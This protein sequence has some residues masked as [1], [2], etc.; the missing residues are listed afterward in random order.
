MTVASKP[1][2]TDPINPIFN[3]QSNQP[4][5]EGQVNYTHIFSPNVVNNFIGSILWYSAIFQS[6]NQQAALNVFPAVLSVGDTNMTALGPGAT[7]L[8]QVSSSH[9]GAMF[10]QWQLVNDLSI[11]RGNHTFKLGVN[12][13][14]DDVSDFTAGEE[15]F[16]FN[17]REHGELR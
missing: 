3:T 4:E 5:D 2:F 6:A 13:R 11:A 8:R 1:T 7:T 16:P 15:N 14:R 12:F 17:D 10:T 9:K